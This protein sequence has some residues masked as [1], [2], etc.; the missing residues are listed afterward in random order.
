MMGP[1]AAVWRIED[2]EIHSN[3]FNQVSQPEKNASEAV[4]IALLKPKV[5]ARSQT[6]GRENG[7]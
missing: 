1:K 2:G 7:G 5:P 6:E 3:K 4:A